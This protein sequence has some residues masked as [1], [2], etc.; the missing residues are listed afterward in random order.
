[1]T[2][3][4]PAKV[5]VKAI[6]QVA[7]VV[8]DLQAALENYWKILGIGPWRIYSLEAPLVYERTTQKT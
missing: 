1:M 4:S 6:N 5:K 3:V 7:L 2:Q 8:K